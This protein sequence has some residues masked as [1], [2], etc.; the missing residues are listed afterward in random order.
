M[1]VV[2]Q[3]TV[4]H[5]VEHIIGSGNGTLDF[6]VKGEDGYYT[7]NGVEDADWD[8]EDVDR[9]ENTEEDRFIVYPV[10]ETFTCEIDAGE[11]ELN[12]GPVRCYCE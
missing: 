2:S 3:T 7:W 11:D 6:A 8:V 9:I 10:G 1:P 4:L 5:D 12:H